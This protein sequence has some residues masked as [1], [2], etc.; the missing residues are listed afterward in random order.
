MEKTRLAGWAPW[1]L[2]LAITAI[3]LGLPTKNYYWDG[4]SFAQTIESSHGLR[5]SLI[6]PNHLIYNT[7][8]W[9]AYSAALKL[10]LATRALYVLQHLNAIFGGLCVC[11]VF[12]LVRRTTGSLHAASV[13]SLLFAFSGTWWKF[14][15]DADA[16]IPSVLLLT[17]TCWLVLPGNRPRPTAAAVTHAGAMFFHQLAVFFFPAA[18][19]AIWFQT[20]TLPAARRCAEILEYALLAGVIT[21]GGF[22]FAFGISQPSHSLAAFVRWITSNSHGPS[23]SF[24]VGKNAVT[25]LQ[26]YIQL[27]FVGR[28]ALVRAADPLILIPAIALV[29]VS[30][31]FIGQLVQHGIGFRI[32]LRNRPVFAVAA[33]WVAAYSAFL[34]FWEPYNAFYKLFLLPGVILLPASLSAE[35]RPAPSNRSWALVAILALFNFT[36]AIVPYSR[37][38]S[39]AGVQFASSL[40]QRWAPNAV[41][42]YAD[43]VNIDSF[44]RYFTPG[45]SW[46][47][48]D[49]RDLRGAEAEIAAT[50]RSG[51]EVWL[52]RTA[53]DFLAKADPG[54]FS[55][56]TAGAQWLEL[57][58]RSHDVRF[59]RVTPAS[60]GGPGL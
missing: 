19:L 6:H 5:P 46:R 1:I 31:W 21:L 24:A 33:V 56:H 30:L 12:L 42:Y 59:V 47:P 37:A 16:Y 54:W 34:F 25:T 28:P 15:T 22:A 11:L 44:S 57:R 49:R 7:V 17:A 27:F 13:L 40:Q 14:V 39:N 18:L 3:Y 2:F 51:R 38:S 10:G 60:T 41:V 50:R 43:F 58:D 8:G 9:L 23:F 35:S 53:I 4:V 20:R 29:L 36:F 26:N 48:L 32:V 55:A 45:A 52:D